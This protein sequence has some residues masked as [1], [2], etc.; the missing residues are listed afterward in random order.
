MQGIEAV[1]VEAFLITE[2][3]EVVMPREPGT[4]PLI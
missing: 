4:R 2:N 1:S 3:S